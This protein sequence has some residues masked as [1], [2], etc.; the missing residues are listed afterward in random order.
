MKRKNVELMREIRLW[1]RDLVIPAIVAGAYMY[2]SP[3][4]KQTVRDGIE[5]FKNKFRKNPEIKIYK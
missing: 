5:N 4:V 3:E 2:S 1:T